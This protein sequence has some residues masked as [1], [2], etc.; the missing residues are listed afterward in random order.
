MLAELGALV[1]AL[2]ASDHPG[3][4]S[5]ARAGALA[6]RRG[7][8]ALKAELGAEPEEPKVAPIMV[9]LEALAE[10]LR[11]AVTGRDLR[12]KRGSPWARLRG[13]HATGGAWHK[14]DGRPLRGPTPLLARLRG[15]AVAPVEYRH[16]RVLAPGGLD[17][18]GL[19]LAW[20]EEE[21]EEVEPPR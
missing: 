11:A 3:P 7:L 12:L 17:W 6:L 8:A 13:I 4:W 10:C 9:R 5:R 2:G 21:V 14:L 19:E 20:P 18:E 1:E 15:G 16:G